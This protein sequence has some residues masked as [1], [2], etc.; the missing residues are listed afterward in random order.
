[1][2]FNDKL[3]S[4]K[5]H[6]SVYKWDDWQYFHIK[7]VIFIRIWENIDFDLYIICNILPIFSQWP[8]F[9]TADKARLLLL[10]R[11]RSMSL[12]HCYY[13]FDL[14]SYIYAKNINKISLWIQVP[15]LVI[16]LWK[17]FAPFNNL[18]LLRTQWTGRR[19]LHRQFIFR[20]WH[21]KS[22]YISIVFT[23]FQNFFLYN[24]YQIK[25]HI[26]LLIIRKYTKKGLKTETR[27]SC[28]DSGPVGYW[29]K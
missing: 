23:N 11:L 2:T 3:S 19:K 17:V 12:N 21:L 4:Q 6:S 24:W 15:S 29:R 27:G 18:I 7:L 10:V 28:S 9:S 16:W 25:I 13:K 14:N 8:W 5:F 20:Y 1:M 26:A 22:H